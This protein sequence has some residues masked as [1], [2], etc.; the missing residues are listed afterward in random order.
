MLMN[1]V[2]SSNHGVWAGV[3]PQGGL[4]GGER[5]GEECGGYGICCQCWT[6]SSYFRNLVL[7]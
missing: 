7:S 5:V 1:M 6:V 4:V 2:K 3:T